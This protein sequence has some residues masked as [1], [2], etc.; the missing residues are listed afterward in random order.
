MPVSVVTSQPQP[1]RRSKAN[2]EAVD[3]FEKIMAEA[4]K[5]LNEA[6]SAVTRARNIY[7]NDNRNPLGRREWLA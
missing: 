6:A 1:P 5:H 3:Q 7:R 2:R 4:Q